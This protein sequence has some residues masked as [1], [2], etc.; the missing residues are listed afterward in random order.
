MKKSIFYS[1]TLAFA[2][3][4]FTS[5]QDLNEILDNHFETI[6]QENLLKVKS[7]QA[8]GK[9]MAMGME[10]P[11]KMSAKRPDKI[12]VEVEFQ[13]AKILQGY[14]GETVWMVNPMTGSAVP[15]EVTGPEAEGLMESADIDG[16]LWKYKEK[17]HQLE[18][19]GT[20]E[21]EGTEVFVL[22][23]TKKNGNI[24][25]YYLDQESYLVLKMKSKTIMNGSEVEVETLL[26]NYQDVDGY[27]MPFTTEQRFGGQTGM[28]MMVDEVNLN[29]ALDD[30]MFSKPAGN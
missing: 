17:G 29:V 27:I 16:Q 13:G 25:Y 10:N 1:I 30:G 23:L 21:V 3:I 2:A 14:D 11:F 7:I 5:A 20:D 18:F 22:K 26:S 28:T 19:E 9:A 4:S 12:L 24:D 6:G 8:T 15:V